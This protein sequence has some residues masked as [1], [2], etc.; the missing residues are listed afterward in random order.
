MLWLLV[1]SLPRQGLSNPSCI[2]VD[3]TPLCIHP[4]LGI[5]PVQVSGG[6]LPI[7]LWGLVFSLYSCRLNFSLYRCGVRD[8]PWTSRW[9][10]VLYKRL[11]LGLVIRNSVY[12]L[13]ASERCLE[14]S[15]RRVDVIVRHPL[16]CRLLMLL[17]SLQKQ[18]KGKQLFAYWVD[19]TARLH[20]GVAKMP[21]LSM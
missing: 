16:S 13:I 15:I 10:A 8:S 18:P 4:G 17:Q 2:G 14:G 6:L 3:S 11:P 1:V 12:Q 7:Y 21:N 20:K 19:L 5:L 9:L